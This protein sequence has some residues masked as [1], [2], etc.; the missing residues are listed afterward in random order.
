MSNVEIHMTVEVPRCKNSNSL[1]VQRFNADFTAGREVSRPLRTCCNAVEYGLRQRFGVASRMVAA[2]MVD[3]TLDQIVN[4]DDTVA[5]NRIDVTG[6]DAIRRCACSPVVDD[7]QQ[8]VNVDTLA[9]VNAIR[10]TSTACDTALLLEA[11]EFI[12]TNC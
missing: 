12:E 4:V 7:V 6:T 9:T 1:L 8:I 11:A 10:F 3:D 2:P 5:R